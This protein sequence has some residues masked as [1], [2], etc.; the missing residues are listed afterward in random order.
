MKG[1]LVKDLKLLISSQRTIV[2]G[3]LFVAMFMLSFDFDYIFIVGWVAYIAMMVSVG[4]INYDVLDNCNAFLF[5]LPFS[6]STYVVEKYVFVLVSTIGS[7]LIALCAVM[8]FQLFSNQTTDIFTLLSYTTTLLPVAFLMISLILPIQ[9]KFGIEKSRVAMMIV[10]GAIFA[11][12][13]FGVDTFKNKV[14][15]N[16]LIT[17]IMTFT[18]TNIIQGVAMLA[19]LILLYVSFV[20]SKNIIEQKEF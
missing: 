4:T 16:E 2:V 13:Y 7:W 8:G 3:L 9:L 5:T 10:F 17:N 18:S 19:G 14:A 1:L 6:R 15:V 20:V 11:V 12:S